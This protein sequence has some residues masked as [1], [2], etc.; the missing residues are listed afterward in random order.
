MNDYVSMANLLGT[1]VG[2]RLPHPSSYCHKV[3]FKKQAFFSSQPECLQLGPFS[4]RT[5]DFAYLFKC[6]YSNRELE[7]A[8]LHTNHEPTPCNHLRIR[9]LR[10]ELHRHNSRYETTRIECNRSST[11]LQVSVNSKE[12]PHN[13]SKPVNQRQLRHLLCAVFP[14]YTDPHL[15]LHSVEK[16]FKCTA[17]A[18]M[19][20]IDGDRLLF[21]GLTRPFYHIVRNR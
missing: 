13:L 4:Q 2:T 1:I 14:Q 17:T 9:H 12:I 3:M 16:V 20:A 21:C 10:T 18:T 5:L 11:I 8:L 6:T 15:S 7:S 19:G